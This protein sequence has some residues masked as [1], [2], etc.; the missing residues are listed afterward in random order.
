MQTKQ[1]SKKSKSYS[2]CKAY[3]KDNKYKKVK[4][5]SKICPGIQAS[6]FLKQSDNCINNIVDFLN[7]MFYLSEFLVKISL[8]LLNFILVI[9]FP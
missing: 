9:S 3:Y 7:Y 5:S 2:I 4:C 8:L 1:E 6:D